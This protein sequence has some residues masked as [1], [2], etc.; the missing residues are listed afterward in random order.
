VVRGDGIVCVVHDSVS[1][2]GSTPRKIDSFFLACWHAN[3][4]DSL[5]DL[6]QGARNG[7]KK[8]N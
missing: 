7:R 3:L 2:Q 1:A 6:K 8:E 4:A 5:N